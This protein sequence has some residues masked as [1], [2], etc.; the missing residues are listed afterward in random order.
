M[1]FNRIGRGMVLGCFVVAAFSVGGC[2]TAEPRLS[3]EDIPAALG[4][5]TQ[6]YLL[7][8]HDMLRIEVFGEED[9][10][11]EIE[12]DDQGRIKFPLLGE[13]NIGGKTAKE[14]EDHLTARLSAGY[15]KNPNIT[16]S[17]IRYRNFYVHGEAR[18]PGAYPYRAGLTVLKAITYAGGLTDRAA[19]G[20]ALVLRVINGKEEMISV[21]MGDSI[22]PDDI[23]IVPESFF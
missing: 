17:I 22:Q 5:T 14:V 2:A 9:L 10:T 23:V 13:L 3:D 11:R 15:L 4:R 7:G 20:R 18:N 21:D 6:S 16:V 1:I 12:V 8:P 19:K